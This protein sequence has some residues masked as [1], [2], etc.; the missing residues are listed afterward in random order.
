MPSTVVTSFGGPAGVI[1]RSDEGASPGA[2]KVV[3]VAKQAKA[4]VAREKKAGNV[5]V[6]IYSYTICCT[7]GMDTVVQRGR[8]APLLNQHHPGNLDAIV[9]KI[10]LISREIRTILCAWG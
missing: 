5:S 4:A 1:G 3:Q 2:A 8:A 7:F 6:L 10:R 9:A